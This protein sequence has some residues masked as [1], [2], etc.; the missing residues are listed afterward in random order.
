MRGVKAKR[1]RRHVYGDHSLRVAR[2]FV[3]TT[4]NPTTALNHPRSLRAA[5]QAAKRGAQ[6]AG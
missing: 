4:T 5:Y 1:V 2:V 3:T 6:R